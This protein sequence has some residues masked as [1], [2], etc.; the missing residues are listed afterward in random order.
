[1]L[2]WNYDAIATFIYCFF[3]PFPRI[4]ILAFI[5]LK[6]SESC[7]RLEVSL[8]QMLRSTSSFFRF[9]AFRKTEIAGLGLFEHQDSRAYKSPI[10]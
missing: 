1:M 8:S 10:K 6:E 5:V 2:C 7:L 9:S 4:A 3:D